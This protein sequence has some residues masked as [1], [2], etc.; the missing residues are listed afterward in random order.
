[1][2]ETNELVCFQIISKAGAAKSKCFEA[3]SLSKM[4]N[5]DKT[6]QLLLE[7]KQLFSEA[8]EFHNSLIKQEASGNTVWMSLLLTHAEDILISSEL[9]Q[10]IAQEF[11]SVYN[12]LTLLKRDFI[13]INSNL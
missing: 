13:N 6:S 9:F 10:E 8:H 5:S 12:E 4:G 11:S 7:A 3:I 2:E 1:M